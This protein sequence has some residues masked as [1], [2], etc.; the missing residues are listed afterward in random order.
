MLLPVLLTC[1]TI[2][3]VET[4]GCPVVNDCDDCGCAVI[5][6]DM[7]QRLLARK[8]IGFVVGVVAVGMTWVSH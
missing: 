2:I 8:K 3:S 1:V 6:M 7:K 4:E 5:D